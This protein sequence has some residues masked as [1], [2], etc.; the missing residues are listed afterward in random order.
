GVIWDTA[1][2]QLRHTLPIPGSS[3]L[4]FTPDGQTLVTARHTTPAGT[5]RS[6]ARW[7]LK[8]GAHSAF[9]L[10]GSGGVVVGA[11]S[12]DGLT[13]FAMSC[14]S[15]GPRLGV[16]DADPGKERFPPEGHTGRERGVACRP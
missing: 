3:L 2:W 9:D 5:K 16:F 6:F 8:T 13:L 10:P 1:T 15:G 7:N 11:V 4:E 12:P 14:E